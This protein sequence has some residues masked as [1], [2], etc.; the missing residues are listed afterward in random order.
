M[1]DTFDS[2]YV[3]NDC[4]RDDFNSLKAAMLCPCNRFEEHYTAHPHDSQDENIA[5]EK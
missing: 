2:E 3:C 1:R 5:A 4:G